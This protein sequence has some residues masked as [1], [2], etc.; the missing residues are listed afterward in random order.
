NDEGGACTPINNTGY[1]FTNA[2]EVYYCVHDSENLEPTECTKQACISG[3]YYY[4]DEAYY[5]CESS[6][7]LVPVMSRYCSY[8][9]N[10]IINFP[11]ALTENTRQD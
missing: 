9:E 8:N 4:I 10:V 6:S 1:Y 7:S 3:Q 2:G 11:L 5:R